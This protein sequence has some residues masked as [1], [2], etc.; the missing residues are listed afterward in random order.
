[1]R[2]A[3]VLAAAGIVA[4]ERMTARLVEDHAR[5]RQLARG[6]AEIA[7][8]R[9]DAESQPTN[10]V[11][12]SYDEDVRFDEGQVVAEL[13]LRGILVA[14][15]GSRKFRLVTHYWIDNAA[16]DRTVAAFAEVLR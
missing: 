1:M 15:T 5:A 8:V 6:L 10:M 2:Q 14:P 16:V 4:L 3:G 9:L 11:F 13:R 12:F 7:T